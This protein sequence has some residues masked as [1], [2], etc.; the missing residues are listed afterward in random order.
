[1]SVLIIYVV[2]NYSWIEWG[3][4]GYWQCGN[5]YPGHGGGLSIWCYC[6]VWRDVY[7]HLLSS[8]VLFRDWAAGGPC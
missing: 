5:Y 8:S 6:L 3:S 7:A 1:M 2:Q 4:A